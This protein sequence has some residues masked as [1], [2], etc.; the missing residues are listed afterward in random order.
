MCSSLTE[1]FFNLHSSTLG[2]SS[3]LSWFSITGAI[4]Q[5]TPH[6]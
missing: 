5:K 1:T 4:F 3:L 2:E 6:R